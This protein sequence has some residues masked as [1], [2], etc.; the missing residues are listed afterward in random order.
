LS[1]EREKG[2]T[3]LENVSWWKCIFPNWNMI[4]NVG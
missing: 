3:E 4:G 1:G 2:E